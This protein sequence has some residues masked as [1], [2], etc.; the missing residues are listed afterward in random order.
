MAHLTVEIQDN[1]I[2]IRSQAFSCEF[3]DV[4]KNRKSLFVFLRALCSPETGK[5]LFTHQQIAEAFGYHDRQNIDNFVG[6]FR[7]SGED[8]QVFLTRTNTKRDRLFPLIEEQVLQCPWLSPH[9]QYLS[10]CEAHPEERLSEKTFR[11]YVQEVDGLRLLK[12][13]QRVVSPENERFDARRYLHDLLEADQL[14][15]AKKKEIVERFPHAQASSSQAKGARFEGLSTEKMQKKLLVVLLYACTV[16]QDVLALLCGVGK[17]SVHNWISEVCGEELEWQILR[18]I[19]CWSG[20]VSVDEKWVKIKGEWWYVL[21]AV[22]AVSGFPLLMDV[23]PSC[24]AMSW[25]C[26]FRRF[27]VMYGMPRLIVCDGSTALAAARQ[28]VFPHV[29]FQLCKF[30]KL[31]NLMKRLRRHIDDPG[32]LTRCVRLARHIF[33]NASTSSRK[34]ALK[35]LQYLAGSEVAS[36][37]EA[38]MLSP[39]RNLTLS[40]TTNASERF[41]RKIERTFAARYGVPTEESAKVLLRS[42]W[43]KELML[44]GQKHIEETS[45]LRSLDLSRI[46]QQHLNIGNIQHFFHDSSPSQTEKLA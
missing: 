36:Y 25:T 7:Q 13:V 2:E 44:N 16:S 43:L 26:F 40:L 21:C 1:R 34:A 11:Q 10:F 45:E 42:L 39:W 5:A 41:N 20:R 38:H 8:F 46:C 12:R 29:R 19:V 18:E 17:T 31:K 37:L 3:P 27:K 14:H 33:T 23:Y 28:A 32:L 30:H 35:R 24:D 22:D 15:H 4:G 9:Q 6:E